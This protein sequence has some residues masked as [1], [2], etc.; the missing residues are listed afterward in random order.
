MPT[1]NDEMTLKELLNH[2]SYRAFIN[3]QLWVF[4][5][6]ILFQHFPELYSDKWTTLKTIIW[7]R[8][9][10]Q[11][12]CSAVFLSPSLSLTI[13]LLTHDYVSHTF[14]FPLV[15]TCTSTWALHTKLQSTRLS[16]CDSRDT[17]RVQSSFMHSLNCVLFETLRWKER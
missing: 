5:S 4:V 10:S 3:P 2:S 13:N 17:V 6:I 1:M 12:I 8:R 11:K 15:E 14:V 9:R 16:L 7:R